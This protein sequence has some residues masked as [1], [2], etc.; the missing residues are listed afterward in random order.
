[1]KLKLK[2]SILLLATVAAISGSLIAT[3][4]RVEGQKIY[5]KPEQVRIH[6]ECIAVKLPEGIFGT[7]NLAKDAQGYYVLSDDLLRDKVEA[8][9]CFECGFTTSSSKL[10][11]Q[12]MKDK[13]PNAR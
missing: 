4:T 2:S 5:V 8:W 9:R 11:S 6:K 3:A 7:M 13:H 1:M 10:L 12:H